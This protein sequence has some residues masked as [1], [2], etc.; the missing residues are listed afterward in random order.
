MMSYWDAMMGVIGFVFS[1]FI[2]MLVA[3]I[4]LFASLVGAI[5]LVTEWAEELWEVILIALGFGVIAW[6][7]ISLFM[8]VS[9]F[10]P[11]A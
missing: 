8:F 10:E 1:P 7:L 4:L 2:V 6:L 11:G 3:I 9:Q 5:G